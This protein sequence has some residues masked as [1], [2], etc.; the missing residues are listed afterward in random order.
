MYRPARRP[1]EGVTLIE[2]GDGTDFDPEVVAVF[3]RVVLPFPTGSEVTLADG[4]D[5]LVVHVDPR[6]PY[7]P[8]VRVAT[9]TGRIEEVER[10]LLDV[11]VTV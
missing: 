2:Q 10:A 7:E 5:G 3:S 9:D 8:T 1:H 6:H 4:R 11:P